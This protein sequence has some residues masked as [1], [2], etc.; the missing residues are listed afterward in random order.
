LDFLGAGATLE[1]R[2]RGAGAVVIGGK[3]VIRGEA[4]VVGSEAVV[5]V[6]VEAVVELAFLNLFGIVA[7]L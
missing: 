6:G 4:V 2:A 1:Q 3:T 5:G 7:T